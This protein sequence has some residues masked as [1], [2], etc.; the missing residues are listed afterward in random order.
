MSGLFSLN[1]SDFFK[2]FVNAALSGAWGAISGIVLA[3]GFDVFAADFKHI[4]GLAIVGAVL[5]IMGYLNKNF[6]TNDKGKVLGVT[7]VLGV[8]V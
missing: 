1:S 7:N 5:S 3:V 4:G 6:L 2:G 8:K